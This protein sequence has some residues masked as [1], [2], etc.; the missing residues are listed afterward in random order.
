MSKEGS[1]GMG[2][3]GKRD[4]EMKRAE[5]GFSRSLCLFVPLSPLVPRPLVTY[6]YSYRGTIFFQERFLGDQG[7]VLRSL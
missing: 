2:D 6:D 7:Y 1:G 4:R 3:E 5:R